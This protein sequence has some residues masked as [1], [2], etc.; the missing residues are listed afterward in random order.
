LSA[1]TQPSVHRS[2]IVLA[3]VALLAVLLTLTGCKGT[4][5]STSFSPTPTSDLAAVVVKGVDGDKPQVTVPTPFSVPAT[6]RRVITQGTGPTVAAGQ[7]VTVQYL[8]I[9]GTDGKEFDS[10][11][12]QGP[13][14][15]VLDPTNN[16][17]GLVDALV[18]TPVGSRL[19]LAV[20]PQDAYGLR[21][22][23]AAGIGPTDTLV[24][25]VDVKA[26]KNVL[27]R[28][29]G[30]A[31]PPKAGLPTVTLD[32]S[33]KPK[34]VLPATAAPTTLVAQPLIV[35]AGAKV[36]KG[37]QI[38]VRYTGWIWPGGRQFDSSW[39]RKVPASFQIGVGAVLA[40]WDDG[41][42]GQTVGSQMLLVIPPDKGYGA[43]GKTDAG[44]K[45]TDTL[46]F[47]VDILDAA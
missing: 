45:G 17:K 8:G 11:Y 46:V 37:Q 5:A 34:V 22:R 16:I 25:V 39:D 28:A 15:F 14:S 41:L 10:S 3:V 35:G 38:T 43:V 31:V 30:K 20:P 29:T 36:D 12:G 7:R 24:I 18:G 2:R 6:D 40:G 26:A 42:I 1:R 47:V 19:L 4:D 33:G 21:G 9:N 23:P 44:I 27:T 13:T 32:A